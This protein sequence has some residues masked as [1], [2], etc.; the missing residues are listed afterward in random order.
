MPFASMKT[1][2]STKKFPVQ[3]STMDAELQFDI[4]VSLNAV[5]TKICFMTIYFLKLSFWMFDFTFM[6]LINISVS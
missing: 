1:F 2:P 3:I 6:H 4:D 5:L